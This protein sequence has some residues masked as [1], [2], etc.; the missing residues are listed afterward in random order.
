ML[1]RDLESIARLFTVRLL[2]NSGGRKESASRCRL[3][4]CTTR[5]WRRCVALQGNDQE[6]VP[7]MHVERLSLFDRRRFVDI[8]VSLPYRHA[9]IGLRR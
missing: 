5:W 9:V 7:S 2:I 6:M 1:G 8:Q 4:S 3:R